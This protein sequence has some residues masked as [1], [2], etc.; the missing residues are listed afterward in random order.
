MNDLR[1][2]EYLDELGE[3]FAPDLVQFGVQCL[4]YLQDTTPRRM[5][6]VVSTMELARDDDT[7]V[8]L[9]HLILDELGLP[10]SLLLEGQALI[11]RR[12]DTSE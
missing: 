6:Y 5:A 3:L 10:E 7:F 8:F 9:A 4:T 11:G 12:K 2:Q 1:T